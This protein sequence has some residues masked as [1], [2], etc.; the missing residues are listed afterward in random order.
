ML[1]KTGNKPTLPEWDEL[2]KLCFFFLPLSLSLIGAWLTGPAVVAATG[3]DGDLT[4]D[5]APDGF[6]RSTSPS[7]TTSI[8][9]SKILQQGS[10]F[11][12][13]P[14][15]T[16]DKKQN[17]TKSRRSLNKGRLWRNVFYK[18]TTHNPTTLCWKRAGIETR[19]TQLFQGHDVNGPNIAYKKMAAGAR[20]FK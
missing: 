18:V 1:G 10:R 13:F 3:V 8:S 9:S 20:H 11:N 4:W 19:S 6:I 14:V 2:F 17:K 12:I 16:L 5:A 7:D 15:V